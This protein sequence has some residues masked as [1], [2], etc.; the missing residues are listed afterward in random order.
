MRRN[1]ERGS[2][3][4]M[5]AYGSVIV[6]VMGIGGATLGRIVDAK[7]ESQNVADS[8][9]L[10]AADSIRVN[11]IDADR[12]PALQLA[13]HNSKNPTT[14]SIDG[15]SNLAN[16][17][18]V[19]GR[20]GETVDTPRFIFDGDSKTQSVARA[21]VDQETRRITAA[22]PADVVFVLDFSGSMAESIPGGTKITTLKNALTQYLNDRRIQLDYAAA[23]F[24]DTL[25]DSVPFGPNAIQQI[26][27]MFKKDD[28]GGG[29]RP[30]LGFDKAT[31][32]LG[33]PTPNGNP[34]FVVFVSDGVPNDL[35][36]AVAGSTNMWNKA[37]PTVMTIH[38]G[39]PEARPFMLSVSG[40]PDKRANP[41]Y[42]FPVED[43]DAF[44]KALA[45]ILGKIACPMNPTTLDKTRL[46]DPS[47]VHAFL[48]DKAGHEVQLPILSVVTD[49]HQLGFFFNPTTL[50]IGVTIE[51]CA[52]MRNEGRTLVI[53]YNR[54]VLVE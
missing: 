52:L 19:T 4:P 41:D 33:A 17:V 26:I 47:T 48:R 38:I 31:E 18:D 20:G 16:E 23:L 7:R 43:I 53:R 10:A 6:C 12:T 21:K 11:G 42:Y 30:E 28:A 51:A 5:I 1:P 46:K 29:T 13:Q 3:A 15:V 8:A 9:A 39:D 24:S 22:N 25:I 34:R 36:A 44:E 35:A 32:F 37:Q 40:P 2:M 50:D 49:L 14:A 45:E 54:A 27:D